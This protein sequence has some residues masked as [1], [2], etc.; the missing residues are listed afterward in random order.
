MSRSLKIVVADDEPNMRD[1]LRELLPRLGHEVV[2]VSDG[3]QLVEICRVTKPDLIITDIKMGG[4]D[5]MEAAEAVNREREVPVI[6]V[7]AYHEPALQARALRGHVMAYLVKP[8]K[9]PDLES[10]IGMAMMRFEHY[11]ALRQEAADLR[12]ALEDRKVIERA[13]GAVTKR[14]RVDEEEAFRRLRKLASVHNRKLVEV[15]QT[16]LAGEMLFAE[17][18]QGAHA[19]PGHGPGIAGG[20]TPRET[21]P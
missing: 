11:R 20:T 14:L 8:V 2:A 3:A 15:A 1:Y 4:L 21:R 19:G 18:E 6:L 10:A 5:G 9:Q 7:S 13:K 16:V 12:Q 17:L